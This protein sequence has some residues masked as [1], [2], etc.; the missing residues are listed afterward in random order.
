MIIFRDL[1]GRR[2]VTQKEYEV[3]AGAKGAVTQDSE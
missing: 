2:E 1:A 3:I